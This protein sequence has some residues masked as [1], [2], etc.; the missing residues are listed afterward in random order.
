VIR[1]LERITNRTN[2]GDRRFLIADQQGS[3]M[4]V[5]NSA[6]SVSTNSYDEKGKPKASNSRRFQF[7]GQMWLSEIG[8]YYYKA[9][10]YNPDLGRFMQTDPIGYGDGLNMYA[11][12]V[13]DPVNMVDP[14]GLSGGCTGSRVV[15]CRWGVTGGRVSGGYY[16]I[17]RGRKWTTTIVEG[18]GGSRSGRFADRPV[19]LGATTFFMAVENFLKDCFVSDAEISAGAQVG[20]QFKLIGAQP[21]GGLMLELFG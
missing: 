11:Y 2:T 15:G 12:V 21:G 3:I 4:A 13:N 9:R 8:L 10:M 16:G 7:T 20:I 19:Y 14:S 18:S 5:V 6:G 17:L 1:M